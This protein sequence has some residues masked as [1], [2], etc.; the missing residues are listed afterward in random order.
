M[1][2]IVYDPLSFDERGEKY[3]LNKNKAVTIDAW[4]IIAPVLSLS[5]FRLFLFL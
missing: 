1:V 3:Y 2:E 4:Y 5:P